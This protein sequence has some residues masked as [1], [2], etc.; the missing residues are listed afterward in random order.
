MELT[1]VL[2]TNAYS[3]WRRTSRWH[4]WISRADSVLVPTV[5]L[6]ELLHGFRKGTSYR[7]N[8][9]GLE[10]F[11]SEPQVH[12]LPVSR[13]TAEIYSRFLVHLQKRGTPIPTNDIWIA[14]GTHETYGKLLTGDAHFAHL[15]D[16]EVAG[17][18][19]G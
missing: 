6:G 16:V 14:A 19:G 1:V 13:R 3:D 8:V 18:Y 15:P 9:A 11:L 5:V 17:P 12:L 10:A 7:K 4:E 2:D